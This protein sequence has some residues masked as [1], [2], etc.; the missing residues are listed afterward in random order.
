MTFTGGSLFSI[1]LGTAAV[2]IGATTGATTLFVQEL[3]VRNIAAFERA[4][5]SLV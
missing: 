3:E 4:A 5:V 1:S 2:V